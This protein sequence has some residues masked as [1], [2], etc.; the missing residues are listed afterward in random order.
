MARIAQYN[1]Q[2]LFL[3]QKQAE[4]QTAKNLLWQAE[5]DALF[6]SHSAY[7]AGKRI[8]QLESEIAAQELKINKNNTYLQTSIMENLFNSQQNLISFLASIS[9]K[10]QSLEAQLQAQKAEMEDS[11]RK[12]ERNIK[13]TSTDLLHP[14]I[15]FVDRAAKL[16]EEQLSGLAKQIKDPANQQNKEKLLKK[17]NFYKDKKEK[18]QDISRRAK[19]ISQIQDSRETSKQFLTL[20]EDLYVLRFGKKPVLTP[21]ARVKVRKMSQNERSSLSDY[22]KTVAIFEQFFNKMEHSKAKTQGKSVLNKLNNNYFKNIRSDILKYLDNHSSILKMSE[23]IEHQMDDIIKTEQALGS[24]D[25]RALSESQR[26][27]N[28]AKRTEEF[29]EMLR[30]IYTHAING[31]NA[32]V[33]DLR[34]EHEGRKIRYNR[35][36]QAL[37]RAEKE[38]S[39]T[40]KK[41]HKTQNDSHKSLKESVSFANNIYKNIQTLTTHQD[42]LL[43][44][45]SFTGIKGN[46]FVNKKNRTIFPLKGV[47]EL[48]KQKQ[49]LD[50]RLDETSDTGLIKIQT[51]LKSLIKKTLERLH[52]KNKPLRPN[53]KP[54]LNYYGQQMIPFTGRVYSKRAQEAYENLNDKC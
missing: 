31:Y 20:A 5:S 36:K 19:A 34:V 30:Q 10:K 17:Y 42:C 4:Q 26:I 12:F 51:H 25:E 52:L 6:A 46:P 32:S 35:D 43:N 45:V 22:S 50:K 37:I 39:E 23:S 3:A 49:D 41:S 21:K 7:F 47:Q 15:N 24:Q 11:I 14:V 29:I 54:E 2:T 53:Q 1:F 18:Y 40:K 28:S 27:Q 38:I 13:L 8:H 9:G 44:P 33:A 48:K 16:Y